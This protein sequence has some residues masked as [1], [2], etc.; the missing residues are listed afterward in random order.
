MAT[1]DNQLSYWQSGQLVTALQMTKFSQDIYAK[2]TDLTQIQS[3]SPSQGLI[4]SLDGISQTLGNVS[5]GAGSFRFPDN[6]SSGLPYTTGI[7]GNADA[8]VIPVSGNGYIVA[9]YD[10]EIAEPQQNY[11]MPTVYKFVST[12]NVPYDCVICTITAGVISGYGTF[13][14]LSDVNDNPITGDVIIGDG[15]VKSGIKTISISNA[16][17]SG[18][19]PVS[20]LELFLQGNYTQ[21]QINATNGIANNFA[22][23]QTT[24]EDSGNGIWKPYSKM[25]AE[26]PDGYKATIQLIGSDST[27]SYEGFNS[28]LRNYINLTNYTSLDMFP[29]SGNPFSAWYLHGSGVNNT[30]IELAINTR[31]AVMGNLNTLGT[32]SNTVTVLNDLESLTNTGSIVQKF[33]TQGGKTVSFYCSEVTAPMASGGVIINMPIPFDNEITYVSATLIGISKTEWVTNCEINSP[34]QIGVTF[35][36]NLSAATNLK[37]MVTG[38]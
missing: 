20:N 17:I 18:N 2:F 33:P 36:T 1:Y 15:P 38:Y 21:A 30:G 11:S 13:N 3:N 31:P 6:N 28:N 32:A 26:T 16:P 5:V 7:F 29:V 25:E 12:L 14:Y 22:N 8:A 35:N 9:E 19:I 27:N 34:G 23:V 10:I 37:F 24:Y 4:L